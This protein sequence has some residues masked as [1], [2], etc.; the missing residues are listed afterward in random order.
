MSYWKVRQQEQLKALEKDEKEL[1]NRLLNYYQAEYAKLDKEIAS[2]YKRYGEKNII[3]YRNLLLELPQQEKKLLIE[4]VEKFAKQ[5]P[6]LKHIVPVRE[7]IYKLN[8][9]EGLQLSI[10][11][12]QFEIGAYNEENVRKHLEK[13]ALRNVN[14]VADLLGFGKNFY[15]ENKEIIKNFVGVKWC[16]GKDFSMRIWQNTEKLANYLTTDIAQGFARGESYEKLTTLLG[17]RFINVTKKD[18]YRVIYTEGTYVMAESSAKTLE[19]EFEQYKLSIV[20]EGTCSKCRGIAENTFN[21]AEREPGVN[22]PP[23]HPMCRCTFEII[24]D[25]WNKWL[26]EYEKKHR[27]EVLTDDE[28]YAI[29]TYI[30]SFSYTLNEKLRRNIKLDSYEEKIAHDLDLALRKFPIYE[31]Y[32][33]RSL[34]FPYNDEL[35]EFINS[36]EVGREKTFTEYISATKKGI[37]DTSGQVQLFVLNSKEGRDISSYNQNENEVLY[38]RNSKFKVI[39]LTYFKEIDKYIVLLEEM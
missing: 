27:N 8:R 22:F 39:K 2:F 31:G 37:Y 36:L 1:M 21:F 7:N 11:M 4:Q 34:S 29:N 30:S 33:N 12:Q 18:V 32:L 35:N 9:L 28:K 6:H 38:P 26:D 23:I 24:V 3:E 19:Q 16:E 13:L 15:F 14:S 17:K 5:Y 10:V 20:G 25:D